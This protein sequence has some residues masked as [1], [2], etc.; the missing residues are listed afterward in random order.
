MEIAIAR[1]LGV[2]RLTVAE[3]VKEME[4]FENT[5]VIFH[6]GLDSLFDYIRINLSLEQMAWLV[7]IQMLLQTL[8]MGYMY[9]SQYSKKT[10]LRERN[11][12]CTGKRQVVF[13]AAHFVFR[14]SKSFAP[15]RGRFTPKS[16]IILK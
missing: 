13:C 11:F 16:Q 9:L 1:I 2:H 7:T 10:I 8:S 4:C 15:I 14:I 5:Q 3:F 12:V 6:F